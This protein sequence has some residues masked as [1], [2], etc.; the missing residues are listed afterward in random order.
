[1]YF[2][3]L[4]CIIHLCGSSKTIKTNKE[5]CIYGNITNSFCKWQLKWTLFSIYKVYVL[6][7]HHL[8]IL[9]FARIYKIDDSIAHKCQGTVLRS[10]IHH[11]STSYEILTC[12]DCS[13]HRELKL[14]LFMKE[15]ICVCILRHI[16][17]R[18][19]RPRSVKPERE[20]ERE[21]ERET[22]TDRDR[23]RQRQTD[24][25]TEKERERHT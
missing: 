13:L 3:F 24:R 22:E 23:Q 19:S 11:K 16:V 18:M 21:R 9:S 6:V 2:E 12:F 17:V 5:E 4:Y 15:N 25:Q 1:M 8:F 7:L 20:R 10:I 14:F